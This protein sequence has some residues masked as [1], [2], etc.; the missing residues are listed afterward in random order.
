MMTFRERL[1]WSRGLRV[2]REWRE[3]VLGAADDIFLGPH[4]A[5]QLVA[6]ETCTM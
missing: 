6:R 1:M 2:I 3:G 5:A 4:K